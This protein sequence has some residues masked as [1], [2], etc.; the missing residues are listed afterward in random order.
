VKQFNILQLE[1][2]KK[3][4]IFLFDTDEPEE[5]LVSKAKMPILVRRL[6]HLTQL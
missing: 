2:V 6:P 5:K 4:F 3:P 1:F